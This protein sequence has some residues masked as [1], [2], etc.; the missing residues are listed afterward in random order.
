VDVPKFSQRNEV[1]LE[2][3]DIKHYHERIEKA[4]ASTTNSYFS[5]SGH[6]G[7]FEIWRETYEHEGTQRS[8]RAAVARPTYYSNPK[9]KDHDSWNTGVV[10][11]TLP[12]GNK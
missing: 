1:G 6:T 10:P 5:T 11:P 4:A 2:I 12:S 8:G 9:L 7:E 3:W